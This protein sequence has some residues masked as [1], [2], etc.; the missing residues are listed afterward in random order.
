M[1]TFG[2]RPCADDGGVPGQKSMR[3][4]LPWLPAREKKQRRN[5]RLV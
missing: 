1:K 5:I 2:K 4:I 3:T